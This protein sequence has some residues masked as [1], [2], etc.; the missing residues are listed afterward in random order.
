MTRTTLNETLG[1]RYGFTLF[2]GNPIRE[3]M[4]TDFLK[5]NYDVPVEQVSILSR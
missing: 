4:N 1:G 2:S 3:I 5:V